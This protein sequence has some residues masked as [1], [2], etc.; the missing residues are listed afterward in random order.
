MDSTTPTVVPTPP[1][2]HEPAVK[3]NLAA[4][5]GYLFSIVG[6]LIV[7]LVYKDKFARF[8]GLQSILL[9]L[10]T[11]A[12]YYILAVL[13]GMYALRGLVGLASF[14]VTIYMVV[15]A[16]QGEKIMLPV[17]GDIAEKNS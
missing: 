10:A 8:H 14:V 1:E 9:S 11:Y 2:S 13:P 16:Y 17:I 12:A 6:G 3:S 4:A 7:Y 5:L 15:K